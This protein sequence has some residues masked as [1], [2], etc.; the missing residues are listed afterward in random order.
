MT[1]NL[2]PYYPLNI[3][4]SNAIRTDFDREA[5]RRNTIY[6]GTP[7]DIWFITHDKLNTIL[8]DEW[9]AYVKDIG[10]VLGGS[11]L[12][13]RSPYYQHPDPHIDT[14]KETGLP[15]ILS[16]NFTV[17]FEDDS[18][19]VWYDLPSSTGETSITPNL[20][21]YMVW[22]PQHFIDKPIQHRRRI[23]RKQLTLVNTMLPHNIVVGAKERWAVSIRIPTK[24]QHEHGITDWESAVEFF[25][26]YIKE[27]N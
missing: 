3:D 6:P 9:L 10:I 12:F 21:P 13:Y 14:H 8:T 25:K 23:G 2:K 26:P 18:E 27:E 16:L 11:L 5:W 1:S 17:D 24:F 4:V 19:M 15:T 20:T 7:V 22:P